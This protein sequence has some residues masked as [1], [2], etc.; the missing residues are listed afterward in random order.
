MPN[1]TVVYVKGRA[2]GKGE[3]ATFEPLSGKTLYNVET[4]SRINAFIKTSQHLAKLGMNVFV[5]VDQDAG[6][7]LLVGHQ[8]GV[9][10]PLRVLGPLDD[11]GIP[12][13][14]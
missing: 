13:C 6:A 7:A 5:A 3:Y 9:R 12:P 14:C 2:V 10:K 8:V 4:A 11:H 1:F